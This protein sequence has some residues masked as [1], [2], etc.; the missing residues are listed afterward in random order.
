MV[1]RLFDEWS[2][3]VNIE[4]LLEELTLEEKCQLLVGRDS[5]HTAAIERLNIP[6]IM[7]ADGPHGLRKQLDS[8]NSM[9]VNE[10]YKA[11]C[12]PPAVT[13][14]SSFDPSIAYKMGEAIANECLYKDV[15]V[16]LGPG[17]NIKRSPLC[18][19]NFEYYSEDPVISGEMAKGFVKGLQSKGVG[20][21]IKHFALNSQETYRMVSSSV[22]DKRAFYEIYGKAFKKAIEAAPSMAMCSYNKVDGIY[23]SE[24]PWLLNDVLRHEF[25]FKGVVVSDWTAVND[26][27]MALKATL[28]L[29]MPGHSYAVHK[30]MKDYKAGLIS[31]EE[32]NASCER[33]LSLVKAKMNQKVIPFDL[34]KNH[35]VAYEIAKESMVLL[36]NKDNILPLQLNDKIAIIGQL[37]KTIRY[38]GGGSSHINAYRVDSVMESLPKNIQYQYSDGYDL[39]GDGFNQSLIDEARRIAVNKDK[40]ILVLGL[41]DA[42]ES[43][44]YDRTHLNLPLGHLELL[45]V[46]SQ[47]T[48][49]IVVVL[50]LGSPI[51]MPWIEDVKG[52]LNAYL[53]GEAGAKAIVDIL[54]GYANPSGRLAETFPLTLESTP[55]HGNFAKG[56]GDVNY[57]ESIYVGYRYFTTSNQNVLFPFGH[58]LSYSSFEYSNLKINQVACNHPGKFKVSVDVKNTGFWVGKEVVQLYVSAP[59]TGV[60]KPVRELKSFTKVELQPSETKTI[61]FNLSTDELGYYDLT[62]KDFLVEDGFYQIQINKNV[63]DVILETA[64]KIENPDC[65]A[66]DLTLLEAKSYY[67]SSGLTFETSDFEKLIGQP[68]GPAHVQKTRPFDLNNTIVDIKKTFLGGII[69]RSARKQ[70]FK[71]MKD[72]DN[73]SKLM[74][75]RSLGETPMRAMVVFSGGMLKM[76]TMYGLLALINHQPFKALKHFIGRD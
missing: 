11:V 2:D 51:I 70:A 30:L 68:V 54:Y 62:Q 35:Q 74:V 57:Q 43:E 45:K 7:M 9:M 72:M 18:G 46:I 39:E 38:Q 1:Y 53:A 73:D 5:W 56:N 42:Y 14:A 3:T 31:M 41:T 60:F 66:P 19:R 27:S 32:I 28:D 52:I 75:E 65:P 10:S 20:A 6:S 34:E 47:M 59:Q 69:Y 71:A 36:K 44:G 37:A 48:D 55:C 16:L 63:N 4:K 67:I 15:H 24:N 64:I 33:I 22:A 61:T 17:L 76:K 8:S 49:N 40:V 13:V 29:E 58:G 25:G 26:R 12:F 23:A 50:Q 21:C